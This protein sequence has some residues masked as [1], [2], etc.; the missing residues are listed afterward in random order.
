MCGNWSDEDTTELLERC[1]AGGDLGEAVVPKRP[2]PLSD[3]LAL[4]V[5]PTGARDSERLEFLAHDHEL[6]YAD[7][8]L[9]PRVSAARAAAFAV[10]GGTVRG[11]GNLRRDAVAQELVDRRA[12]HLAAVRAE[13]PG[14]AL[15][16]HSRNR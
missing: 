3:R 9:V 10:E 13:L 6:E 16:K 12:V 1:D 7:P 4:D 8:A 5:L 2:H 11:G 15:R 14:Q